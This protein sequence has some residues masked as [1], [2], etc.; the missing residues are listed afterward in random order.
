MT[1]AARCYAEGASQSMTMVASYRFGPFTVDAGSYRL[2]RGTEV[3]PLSPKIIDLLLYLVARQSALVP[4]DELFAALWPDVAV[5]DNA[6]TQAVSELRQALGDDSSKP[7]VHSDGRAPRL[8]LHRTGRGAARRRQAPPEPAVQTAVEPKPP[9]IAVHGFHQ[10]QP[11]SRVRLAVIGHRRN[12]HERSPRRWHPPHHRPRPRRRSGASESAS[13][14]PRSQADLHL[15]LAVVGS[16]QRSGDRLRITARVVDAASGEALAEAKADGALEQVFEL[17]DRI[18]AQFAETL[19]TARAEAAPRG[20]L[21][22][23]PAASRRTRRSRKGACGSNRSTRRWLPARSLISSARFRSIRAMRSRTS[24]SATRASVSTRCR[25]RATS[26]MRRCSRERSITSGA[27][28]S[29]SGISRRRTRPTHSCSSA[30]AASAKRWSAARRAVT[31]EPGYWGNQFRLAHAAWGEERLRALARAMELYPGFPVRAF[32]GRD[33]AHRPRGARSR[34]I[35]A[36]RRHDRSGS[37]GEPAGSGTRRKA[38]TGCSVLSGSPSGDAAEARAEFQREI[39]VGPTQLYAAEFAMN[40]YDGAGFAYLETGDSGR[41]RAR[42]SDVRSSCFRSMRDRSSALARRSPPAATSGAAD[43]AFAHAL[44][45]HRRAAAG[46]PRKRGDPRRSV[47]CTALRGRHGRGASS[48][49]RSGWW[50]ARAAVYGLDDPDR[51]AVRSAP[52]T[53]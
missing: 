10:R 26:R 46:R 20:T 12:R 42:C 45:R 50:R 22:A 7:D 35:G 41:R 49:A 24:A 16:F 18:V 32:R 30:P 37:P 6:L 48:C 3:I 28:S 31:L 19:G 39:A 8:S 53:G 1:P 4:K 33:G 25:A 17:Q 52:P 29:W 38:C 43:A 51:A 21:T 5:T 47:P 40:A 44:D 9:A 27:R 11:R 23:K 36:A 2:L 14:W 13:T 15:D 34:R